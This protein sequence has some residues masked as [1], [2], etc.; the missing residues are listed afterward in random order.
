MFRDFSREWLADA[1][2]G[3]RQSM[4]RRAAVKTNRFGSQHRVVRHPQA[5]HAGGSIGQFRELQQR[6]GNHAFGLYAQAK[7]KVSDPHDPHEQEADRVAEQVIRTPNPLATGRGFNRQAP[8]IQRKC[9]DCEGEEAM[10][11]AADAEAEEEEPIAVSAKVA[12]AGVD[13]ATSRTAPGSGRELKTTTDLTSN[14]GGGQPLP[15]S[16]RNFFEPRFGYDFGQVRIHTDGS[17]VESATSL[18]A[19]A[20][21]S[22]RDIV[23]A[24]GQYA[25]ATPDG[26]RL[27][28][29]ELTHVVQQERGFTP[30]TVQRQPAP[31]YYD[32]HSE[33]PKRGFRP[34]DLARLTTSGAQLSLTGD[35]S[36]LSAEIQKLLLDNIAATIRFALDPKDPTRVAELQVLRDFIAENPE[37]GPFFDKPAERLDFTDLYHGHI[38]VPR[39]ILENKAELQKLGKAVT[40]KEW[41]MKVAIEKEI[42]V[43]TPTS[44]GE[45][46][47]LIGVLDK[48]RTAYLEALALVLKELISVPE[49]GVEY[50]SWE[51]ESRSPLLGGKRLDRS[52]PVRYIFTPFSTHRPKFL[53]TQEPHCDSLGNFTFHVDQ[54]GRIVILPGASNVE[55]RAY[56]IL[57]DALVPTM[58]PAEEASA[59]T[60]EAPPA[61]KRWSISA[62]AGGDV[63]PDAQRLA[64]ALGGRFSLRSDQALIFNPA[65]GFNLVYLPSSSFNSSHLLAATG[66]VTARIQ[67]PLSGFYFDISAGGYAGFDIDPKRETTTEFTGGLTAAAGLGW[68]FERVEV[69]AEVRALV[70]EAEFD[71]T[72][73]LVFGR[74]AWRFGE[75]EKKPK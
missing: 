20:Y 63:T 25:P 65:I 38:C 73:V 4:N 66:D 30:A 36:P 51:S 18:N 70:P 15:A 46:K 69:G 32:P 1:S 28:G 75:G 13:T 35:L 59:T 9:I 41:A 5:M 22:G 6:L 71:R 49:A 58:R 53:L 33:D 21:T 44:R 50:H 12:A 16:V 26:R 74:A 43:G 27:L 48:D 23:F 55:A 10:R 60:T 17:A 8:R 68:R 42:G 56:E 7:L 54:N 2:Q 3:E 14:L 61:E 64:L 11:K 34:E 31:D 62:A 52:H 29:H 47:K 37:K 45:A 19:V 24:E 39:P 40:D 72:N 67:Q 57:N